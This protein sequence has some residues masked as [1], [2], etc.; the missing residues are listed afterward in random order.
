MSRKHCFFF[1]CSFFVCHSNKDTP[2]KV[3]YIQCALLVLYVCASF[4]LGCW[5]WIFVYYYGEYSK[6]KYTHIL[7][8]MFHTHLIKMAKKNR[9]IPWLREYRLQTCAFAQ[10]W[11]QSPAY[12]SCLRARGLNKSLD[13][14]LRTRIVVF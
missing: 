9:K 12:H 2:K 13:C 5:K 14:L 4:R 10:I 6:R 3:M 1:F 11:I 8:T 7:G